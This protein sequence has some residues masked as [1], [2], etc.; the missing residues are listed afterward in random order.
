[1]VVGDWVRVRVG[2]EALAGAV[3]GAEVVGVAAL[4]PCHTEKRINP[5]NPLTKTK[6]VHLH[7]SSCGRMCTLGSSEKEATAV[8]RVYS[9]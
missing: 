9:W 5:R 3:A 7:R 1:M 4:K 2:A 8:A 6:R